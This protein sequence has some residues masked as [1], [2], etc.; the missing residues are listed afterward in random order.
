M[1][2]QPKDAT[3]PLPISHLHDF[4][5]IHDAIIAADG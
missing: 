3:K 1:V 4:M 2:A 5:G